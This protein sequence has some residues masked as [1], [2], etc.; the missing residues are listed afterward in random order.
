[1][2]NDSPDSITPTGLTEII[3]QPD[4]RVYVHGISRDVLEMIGVLEVAESSVQELLRRVGITKSEEMWN[5]P[6]S[7]DADRTSNG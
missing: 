4:G 7:R 3:F 1:M 6:L 5:S 2:T